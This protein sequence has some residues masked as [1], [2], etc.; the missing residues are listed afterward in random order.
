MKLYAVIPI[1]KTKGKLPPRFD[2]HPMDH[3]AAC[4]W[5]DS[6]RN[7][8]TDYR[9][10]EWPKS[11]PFPGPPVTAKRYRQNTEAHPT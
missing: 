9:L 7:E 2:L 6:C 10:T 8:H 1:S 4:N 3:K 5:M 11:V